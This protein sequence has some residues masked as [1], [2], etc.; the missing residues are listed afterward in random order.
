MATSIENTI[1]RTERESCLGRIQQLV[2]T[3]YYDPHFG[4][5]D[6][7]TVVEQHRAAVLNSDSL[8]EFEAAANNMLKELGS[9]ALG[10]L[11]EASKISSR[12]AIAASF[13]AVETPSDGNRWVFQDVAPGG[14]ADRAGIKPGDTLLQIGADEIVPPAK[15]AFA[16]DTE[17]SVVVRHGNES[18]AQTVTI[19]TPKAKHRDNPAAEPRAVAASVQ[20][21]V[22]ILKVSL[23][24]G[25]LGIDF[26]RDV[27]NAIEGE[28]KDVDA[29]VIDLRGNPGGGIGGL[30]LMSYLTPDRIPIGYS[31][32][33]KLAEAG[34]NKERLPRFNRIPKTKWE[35]P[36]LAVRYARKKSV[37]LETEGL[38]PRR[39]HGRVAI[40]VNEHTTCAAEMVALFAQER[41]LATIV[42]MPT[43]GR[44]V[45][46]RGFNIGHGF[47]FVI[48]TAAYVSWTG[49]RLD[50]IGLIPDWKVEWS[51]ST[52]ASQGSDIQYTAARESVTQRARP[53]PSHSGTAA[54]A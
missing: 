6:W 35:V 28:L 29:L 18:P 41:G 17:T 43:P 8:D 23:F 34:Y 3:K 15:P 24:P 38:G 46:H 27:T 30:R 4:G 1:N 12:N 50:G 21:G 16:M 5:K 37:V 44:L 40:I 32:D 11:R 42:G 26:A 25:K 13:R 51:Y 45:S 7:D 49:K 52:S 47:T 20:D 53:R 22:G 39:F 2:K 10:L 14:P 31:V 9:G 54:R 36:L 48:P 19:S 33:R